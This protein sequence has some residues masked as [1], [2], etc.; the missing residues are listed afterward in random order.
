MMH[1]RAQVSCAIGGIEEVVRHGIDGLLVPPAEPPA[2]AAAI[3]DLIRHPARRVAMGMAGRE[4]YEQ[5]FTIAAATGRLERAMGRV[6]LS[7][8]AG[9]GVAVLDPGPMLVTSGGHPAAWMGRRTRVV[10]SPQP[11]TTRSAAIS[12]GDGA[13]LVVR[14]RA[15]LARTVELSPGWNHV[16]LPRVLEDTVLTWRSGDL[17]FGGVVSVDESASGGPG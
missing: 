10:V 8:V 15:S 7:D 2:L 1:A 16:R 12:A 6:S 14:T 4:R 5:E 9:G 17:I 13:Q 11:G 3:D